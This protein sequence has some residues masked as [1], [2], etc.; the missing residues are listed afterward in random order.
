M[1]CICPWQEVLP[2]R[3]RDCNPAKPRITRMSHLGVT[4]R[5]T[6]VSILCILLRGWDNEVFKR[7]CVS[8][9]GTPSCRVLSPFSTSA[10]PSGGQSNALIGHCHWPLPRNLLWKAVSKRAS[11]GLY[12]LVFISL[13]NALP[14]SVTWT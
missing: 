8:K 12:L 13:C 1:A 5:Q 7:F 14:L 10:V 6:P 3:N 11:N 9:D 2:L 4:V